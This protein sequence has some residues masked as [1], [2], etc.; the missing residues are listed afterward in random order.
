MDIFNL[1]LEFS[2]AF[3]IF[4]II[5]SGLYIVGIIVKSLIESLKKNNAYDKELDEAICNF[6]D[7]TCIVRDKNC[8]IIKTHTHVVTNEKG[9]KQILIDLINF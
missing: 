8:N 5:F 7:E 9:A 4:F 1:F 2:I 6:I 3:S